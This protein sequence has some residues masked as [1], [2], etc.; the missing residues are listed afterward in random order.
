MGHPR[1]FETLATH[2]YSYAT[3]EQFENATP[4]ALTIVLVGLIPTLLLHQAV[5]GG[6]AGGRQ[7]S[8]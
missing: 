6:R 7:Q 3:L 2:V 5:V 8:P 1:T 4:G